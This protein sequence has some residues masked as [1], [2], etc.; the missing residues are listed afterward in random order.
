AGCSQSAVS[1]HINGKLNGSLVEFSFRNYS[2]LEWNPCNNGVWRFINNG[3][4]V[5]RL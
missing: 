5:F 3:S 2:L 1:K 4:L